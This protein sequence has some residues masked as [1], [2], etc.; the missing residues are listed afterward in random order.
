MIEAHPATATTATAAS[1][2][3]A[4]RLGH[5]W[6]AATTATSSAGTASTQ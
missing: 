6:V 1:P 2:A 4:V 5:R 3:T